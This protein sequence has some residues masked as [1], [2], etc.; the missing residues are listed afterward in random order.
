VIS[1][2]NRVTESV[3]ETIEKIGTEIATES[4]IAMIEETETRNEIEMIEETA[5]AIMMIEE[6]ETRNETAI[7]I[8]RIEKTEIATIETRNETET[9]TEMIKETNAIDPT[10]TDNNQLA[11]TKIKPPRSAKQKQA[12]LEL[13]P[14]RPMPILESHTEMTTIDTKNTRHR[15]R[16]Q[17]SVA[18]MK[19]IRIRAIATSVIESASERNASGTRRSARR[20]ARSPRRESNTRNACN[21]LATKYDQPTSQP[22]QSINQTMQ[23]EQCINTM[24]LR[25]SDQC[26]LELLKYNDNTA[27]PLESLLPT[28]QTQCLMRY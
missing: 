19:T 9:E 6:I 12:L 13:E 28:T 20:S 27:R 16:R 10:R 7:V 18:G 1:I 14:H 8:G 5:I 26:G 25:C 3:T 24:I 15:R 23:R 21:E 22:D 4:A 11:T 2:A 17:E